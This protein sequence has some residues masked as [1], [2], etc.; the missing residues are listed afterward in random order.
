MKASFK[1]MFLVCSVCCV[2]IVNGQNAPV[3]LDYS[4]Y[5]GDS[6]VANWESFGGDFNSLL[7]VF[8][9]GERVIVS[10][11]FRGISSVGDKIDQSNPN[12]PAGWVVSVSDFG[13][14]DIAYDGTNN[15]LVLDE[16]GDY[17]GTTLIVGSNLTDF[18]INA[19][20]INAEG[21][22]KEN[23]SIFKIDYYDCDGLRIAGGQIE[24]L[25]FASQQSLNMKD[26]LVNQ[27][28]NVGSIKISIVTDGDRNVGDLMLESLS[29]TYS[30]P[31]YVLHQQAV[32][33][34]S[35]K[36]ENLDPEKIYWYYLQGEKN[37]KI[38]SESNIINVDGFLTPTA[39]K[40]SNVGKTSYTANWERLPKAT[41]YR[42]QNY[43]FVRAQESGYM[44]IVSEGFSKAVEGT[45]EQPV[46]VSSP[47]DIAD[48]LG[49]T[50]NNLI[51]AEGM[52]G[53]SAGRF[54][55]NLSY[56]H[57]PKLNLAGH[58][59]KYKIFIK[60]R[61]KTGDYLSVYRVDYLIDTDGDGNSDKLNIHKTV[62]FDENG[63]LEESWEM[64]DGADGM[65][66]SFEENKMQ[67]FLIDEVVISQEVEA[68]IVVTFLRELAEIK[69]GA[70]TSYSF[71]NLKEGSKYGYD[72]VGVRINDYQQEEVSKASEVIRVQCMAGVD[73][74]LV[75]DSVQV[76]A[77]GSVVS[78]SMKE[79]AQIELYN[80]DGKLVDSVRGIAGQNN[81][82]VPS[83]GIYVL[84]AG[85][86]VFKL[87]VR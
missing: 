18:T 75:A 37:G 13:Q 84:K 27:P 8:E 63:V 66:L 62:P 34:I 61:G 6:F 45:V 35:Y 3:A 57:S 10:E 20:L 48:N 15:H 32:D 40:A 79:N 16:S 11:N 31:K 39:V 36:V 7:S 50:G 60:A 41:G 67:Q 73:K 44:P 47:D 53:A 72:I 56:V 82:T 68:G 9:E 1:K 24:A 74:V 77:T 46:R 43:E 21:I 80:I 19:Y 51:M 17:V 69:D 76:S 87:I 29:Y 52:M 81:L 22:T 28:I 70:T 54:P 5:R 83:F 42:V 4:D 25:F 12:Y 33:G 2:E 59:S 30:K 14:T 85:G 86:L 64:T 26:A 55:V 65:T 71:A 23:S 38:S 49:W 58:G 78:V